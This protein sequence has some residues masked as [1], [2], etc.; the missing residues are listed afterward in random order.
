ML[1]RVK[2]PFAFRD[3][4]GKRVEVVAEVLVGEDKGLE[5]VRLGCDFFKAWKGAVGSCGGEQWL[6]LDG[7][8]GLRV[9]VE[10]V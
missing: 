2:L 5:G 3:E 6:V 9:S 7:L 8:G 4:T 10:R 1:K